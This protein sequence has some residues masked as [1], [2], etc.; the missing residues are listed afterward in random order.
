MPSEEAKRT[1][2]GYTGPE[3]QLCKYGK[4]GIAKGRT[5]SAAGRT[6]RFR[7]L[8]VTHGAFWGMDVFFC[9]LRVGRATVSIANAD[10]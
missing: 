6:H 5:A 10:F 9:T 1:L 7:V 4:G 8:H 2:D 3:I